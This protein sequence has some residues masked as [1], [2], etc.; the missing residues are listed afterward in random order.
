ML[1]VAV[2]AVEQERGLELHVNFPESTLPTKLPVVSVIE[3]V[4]VLRREFFC[5]RLEVVVKEEVRDL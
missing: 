4:S 1:Q 3:A 5:E 2:G